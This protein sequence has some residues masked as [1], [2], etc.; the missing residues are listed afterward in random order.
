MSAKITCFLLA[1]TTAR[2]F[3]GINHQ[4]SL[5]ESIFD[6]LGVISTGLILGFQRSSEFPLSFMQKRPTFG[7][8][9]WSRIDKLGP[10]FLDSCNLSKNPTFASDNDNCHCVFLASSWKHIIRG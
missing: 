2:I 5:I 4:T 9:F 10:H 7:N 3:A 6:N 1:K 8:I